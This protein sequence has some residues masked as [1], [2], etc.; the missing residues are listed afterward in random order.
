[1]KAWREISLLRHSVSQPRATGRNPIQ[2][3]A[4]TSFLL[5]DVSGISPL[6]RHFLAGTTDDTSPSALAPQFCKAATSCLVS[7]CRGHRPSESS[8]GKQTWASPRVGVS[9]RD[10]DPVTLASQ[11]PKSV[12]PSVLST[13]TAVWGGMAV[14]MQSPHHGHKHTF[15]LLL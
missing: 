10:P 9:L 4:A 11:H 14:P 3:P 6:S 13:V 5:P 8:G 15:E 1:M 12:A 7:T 2:A